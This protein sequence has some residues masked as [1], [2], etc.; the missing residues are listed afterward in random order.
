MEPLSIFR[1]MHAGRYGI[2]GIQIERILSSFTDRVAFIDSD[3][4]QYHSDFVFDANNIVFNVYLDTLDH[5]DANRES[6][7]LHELAHGGLHHH[8]MVAAALARKAS[9]GNVKAL[10]L[11]L[12][13][14]AN[15]A[16]LEMGRP[17]PRDAVTMRNIADQSLFTGIRRHRVKTFVE[18]VDDHLPSAMYVLSGP[19]HRYRAAMRR[20]YRDDTFLDALSKMSLTR[21]LMTLT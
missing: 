13:A 8:S 4:G 19:A 3:S 2:T 14:L 10:R 15:D 11:A 18:L 1:N 17:A 6:A 20:F 12:D 7:I 16:V 5:D 21:I 9:T